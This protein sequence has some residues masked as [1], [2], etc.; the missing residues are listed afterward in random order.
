MLVSSSS[1]SESETEHSARKHVHSDSEATDPKS[2]KP[3]KLT[4]VQKWI[5]GFFSGAGSSSAS[6]TVA[7]VSLHRKKEKSSLRS[8]QATQFNV[9]S[10][11][12]VYR[13]GHTK[14]HYKQHTIVCSSLLSQQL[15]ELK[16]S[17]CELYGLEQ[18]ARRANIG[19]FEVDVGIC[20]HAADG[21][22]PT[23][24]ANTEAEWQ[25]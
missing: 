1:G 5:L 2:S 14:C 23:F 19:S 22:L 17:S 4:G 18:D 10:I 21:S 13:F 6:P 16:K 11:I 8:L 20:G 24:T 12:K 7:N 9:D 15:N 3:A 25:C